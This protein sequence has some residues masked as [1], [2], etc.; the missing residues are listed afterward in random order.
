MADADTSF[1]AE[2][3]RGL[4]GRNVEPWVRRVG[5]AAFAAVVVVA[6]TGQLGQRPSSAGSAASAATLDVESPT[7]LRGGLLYQARF[8]ITAHR[9]LAHTRLILGPGWFDGLTL[10]T[11]EPQASEETNENGRVSFAYGALPAGKRLN[12]WLEYQVNPTT[13]G[14]RNQRVAIQDGDEPIAELTRK[15]RIFP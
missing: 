7:K 4:E 6:L 11:T 9:R 2:R 13:T 12:V 10:N 1:S 5:V 15:T 8:T 14:T 3:Y